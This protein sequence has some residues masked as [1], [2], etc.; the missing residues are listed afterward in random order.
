MEIRNLPVRLT[1]EELQ[2]KG[3]ELSEVIEK[4]AEIDSERAG[5]AKQF[6]DKLET[7]DDKA[8]ELAKQIRTKTEERPV[9]VHQR[10]DQLNATVD[11]Y[12]TDTGEVVYSRPMTA[13]ELAEARQLRLLDADKRAEG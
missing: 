4:H 7:L 10:K 9:E 12:R 11:L 6:K 3:Q 2:R 1:E 8:R 5:I 13:E